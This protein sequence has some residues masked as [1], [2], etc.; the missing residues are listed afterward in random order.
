MA[1]ERKHNPWPLTGSWTQK[2][3]KGSRTR[4]HSHNHF[5]R[6]EVSNR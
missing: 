2:L 5:C 6:M 4:L 1:A 3:L